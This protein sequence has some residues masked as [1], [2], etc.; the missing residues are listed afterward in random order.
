MIRTKQYYAKV[1][2][3]KEIYQKIKNIHCTDEE[4]V[5]YYCKKLYKKKK[6]EITEHLIFCTLC[7]QRW[8]VFCKT[9]EE[10]SKEEITEEDKKLVQKIF[11]DQIKRN[12]F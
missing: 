6:D 5:L 4:L 2:Y 7:Q 11:E 3:L 9:L 10:Y 12:S 1:L 8:K